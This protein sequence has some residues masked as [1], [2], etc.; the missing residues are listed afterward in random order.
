[1]L[2]SEGLMIRSFDKYLMTLDLNMQLQLKVL[3][4][5]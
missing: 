5:P 2:D 3:G 4:Q 1:M